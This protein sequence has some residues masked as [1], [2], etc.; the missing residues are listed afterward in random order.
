MRLGVPVSRQRRGGD[1]LRRR[2]GPPR[3]QWMQK[4]GLEWAF[5]LGL[6]PRR[7]F[8]RYAQQRRGSSPG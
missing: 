6:E 5:R 4:T 2:A 8:K 3:P 7:L 1:R